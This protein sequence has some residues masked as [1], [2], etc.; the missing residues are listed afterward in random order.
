MFKSISTKVIF[1]VVASAFM[2]AACDRSKDETSDLSLLSSKDTVL[3]YVP[4]DT[5]YVVANVEPLPDDLMDKLEPKID[6]LMRSY[7]SMLS[8][9]LASK[10]QEL[11]EAERN[12]E[13]YQRANA[14]VDELMTLMSIEGMR[15]AGLGRDATGVLYGNGLLPVVR[16]QLSDG[17][18]F[19]D[20]LSRLESEAGEKLPVAE[21][22]GNSI[23]Y[24]DADQVKILLGVINDQAV[25]TVAPA[26]FDD[27]QL[28]E[29]LGLKLPAKSIADSGALQ[30]I[31]K[32]Y[33]F[34]NH[35]VGYFDF[36]AIADRFVG[37]ASGLDAELL[38]LIDYDP[39]EL[40]SVCRAEIRAVAGIAPRM[41]LGYTDIDKDKLD[42]TV[43][44]ELRD[45]IAAGVQTLPAAVPGL[46]GDKGALMSFGMSIDM[47]AARE[48]LE[49]RLDA[50]EAKPFECEYFADLQ[51]GVAGGRQA[52]NQPLPPM[53]YDFKGFLA[54]IDEI[55][56]LDVATQTPPTSI[57]GSFLLAMNNAE[58]LIAMG[59]MFSPEL[60]SLNLQADGNPVPLELPQMQAMGIAAFAA[61]NEN[62]LA[63]SVGE[64]SESELD[65]LLRAAASD[66]SP[67]MSFS[68]D[69]A[70]YYGF[71][72]E[73]M[74]ADGDDKENAPT[75][76]MQAA[77]QE[78][79][80]AVASVYDRMSVDVRFTERGVELISSVTLQD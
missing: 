75:A 79:M 56:G 17:A 66:P 48:F 40:S 65:G 55:E 72:G 20:A 12:S 30:K 43:V 37:E 6:R 31:A 9:V 18:L 33:G 36:Q 80:A 29:V 32:D 34:T 74:A 60:A 45:D 62:A 63:I 25:F 3:Q 23:R 57:D 14:V 8:A 67:F 13:K 24:F 73:A 21:I 59:A 22:G 77:M 50:M 71:L 1:S 5:P 68:M 54:V 61:M 7:Q 2:L 51:A 11:P 39:A 38:A 49:A 27:A 26:S 69:A 53:V 46:G 78:V 35:Y 28:G 47:K 64:D 58:A 76:E 4:A 16:V 15:S 10:Q 41:V 52:L 70:R 42:S 19:E 44:I